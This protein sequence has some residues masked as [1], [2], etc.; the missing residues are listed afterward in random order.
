M[1]LPPVT[2]MSN[3]PSARVNV[4]P[5]L[6]AKPLETLTPLSPWPLGVNTLPLMTETLLE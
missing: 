1:I 5:S 6:R 3:I 2:R 4:N